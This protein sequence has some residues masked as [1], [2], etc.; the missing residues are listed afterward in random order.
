MLQLKEVLKHRFEATIFYG[1]A[2][3]KS[4][5]RKGTRVALAHR[6]EEKKKTATRTIQ[7]IIKQ[8]F[9][10]SLVE[11]LPSIDPLIDEHKEWTKKLDL[12]FTAERGLAS[13]PK[14]KLAEPESLKDIK[15]YTVQVLE[16]YAPKDETI[17]LRLG[18][19][20]NLVWSPV[21]PEGS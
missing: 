12:A 7:K 10:I 4:S 5:T 19:W 8:T 18:S 16:P 9:V 3:K 20:V 2:K 13:L 21:A 17:P 14:A 6:K 1:G 15:F 11:D